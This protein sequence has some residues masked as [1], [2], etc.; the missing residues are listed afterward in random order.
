MNPSY[1]PQFVS[2]LRKL[3]LI[4]LVFLLIFGSVPAVFAQ[5]AETLANSNTEAPAPIEVPAGPEKV[6][7]TLPTGEVEQPQPV[8]KAP[9]DETTKDK[10]E[11]PGKDE[12]PETQ[13]LSAGIVT[14][15]NQMGKIVESKNRLSPQV[16][17]ITG[18]LVYEYQIIVPPG[19]NQMTPDVTLVYN[20]AT[21]NTDSIIGSGWDFSIP[22]IQRINKDGTNLMYSENYFSSSMD[23]ELLSLGSGSFGAKDENG[24]FNKYALAS[25]VWTVTDKTGTVYK[26][27]NTVVTRQ[28]N[29]A[30]T[31]KVFKWLLEEVRDIND[32]YIKYE[33]FKDAGQIYPSRIIY[34][35][36]GSTDG[37]FEVNFVRTTRTGASTLYN[38]GFSVKSNYRITEINTEVNNVWARKYTL[39]YTTGDNTSG[40]FLDTITESGQ[41]DSS[42]VTTLPISNFNYETAATDWTYSSAWSIPLPLG[43]GTTD[44][45][46]RMADIN[47]D[48]LVDL[49]CH[50]NSTNPDTFCPKT[51]PKVFLNDGDG[52]WT[53]VSS[54]WLFPTF[55][56]QPTIR[57]AFLE[58]NFT[59]TGL[60]ILD[61]NGD[62]LADLAR[63][64]GS[65]SVVYLNNGSG[66]THNSS[67]TVPVPFSPEYGNRVVDIN[68]DGLPDILCHNGSNNYDTFCPKAEPKVY[69]NNGNGTWT[70]VST[71][72]LFPYQ[73]NSTTL[74]E[75]FVDSSFRP[76][77]LTLIDI[78]GDGLADLTRKSGSASFVYLNNG[79]GWTWN[80]SWTLPL[81][82]TSEGTAP[83][84]G[85]RIADINGDSLS[86]LLCS[87][88]S[89]NGDTLCPNG[90]PLVYLNN[91]NGTWTDASSSWAFPQVQNQP[92]LKEV[93]L[94][95]TLNDTGLRLVDL[96]G[97]NMADLTRTSGSF[98][99]VYLNNEDTLSNLL[100]NIAHPQGGTTTMT[101]KATPLFKDG[102]N[103]LLNPFLPVVS[104]VVS[105][106]SNSDGL[107]LNET[108]NYSY[109]GGNYYFS[110]NLDRKLAGFN[111]VTRTDAAGNKTI[112]FYHQGNTTDSTNGEY[113]DHI[114]KLGRPYRVEVQNSTGSIFSKT[115]NQWDKYDLGSGR[116][117]VKNIRT[118]ELTYDGDS[119]H[120]DKAAEYTYEN[121]YGNLTTSTEWGE[122]TGSNDGTFTDT[123]T[124]KFT[125]TISYAA[126]TTPYIMGLPSQDTRVDQSSNKVSENNYY[127]D[128]QTQGNVTDG[129]LT[130]QEMW[131]T[132]STYIDIEKTY[133]TTY[134]I[135][136]QEKDPRDK[137]TNYSYDSYNLYPAT[138]TNA[139]SQVTSYTYDY[140]SGQVQQVTNLNTRVY[141]SVYD[142]LNRVTEQKQP[143][144]ATPS[145]LVTKTSYTYTDTSGAVKVQQ[146]DYLDGPTSVDTHTYFDGL[147]RP[148]QVR[149][150][151]EDTNT[152]AVVDTIYNDI[153]QVYKESVPYSS[154]GSAK[155][156]ATGTASLLITYSYDPMRRVSSIANAI[157]ATST[158]YDDW[159]T[160]ITDPR[161]KL[162][163][164]YNDAYGN[165]V[166][167][168]ETNFGNTYTTNY[169]YNGN[170][171]LT[172]I[173]DALGNVRNFTYDALGRRLTAQDSHAPTDG[174]YGSYTYTY[175]DSGNLTSVLDPKSQTINYV[176]DDLNRVATEDYAG[177]AGTEEIYTYDSGTDGKG[178]LTSVTAPAVSTTYAY[179]ANGN[180][181]QEVETI[182][183]TGYQ[184]DYTFDR[185]GNQLEITNP[186][187]SKIKYTYN[188]AGQLETVQRKE[189]TDGSFINVV[190]D[191]DYGPHGKMTY[192]ALQNGSA[193][194]NTYD[195][196]KMYRLSNKTTT[197]TGGSKMQDSTYTYDTNS[198]VTRIVDAS[199][200]N[201]AKTVDYTYD[202]LNRLLSAAATNVASGQSTYTHSY[203]YD[204]IGNIL[205]RTDAAGTYTYAGNQG[206]SYANPH[207]VT[208]IGS[209]NY[210]YDNNGNMLTETNGLSNVWDYDNRLAQTTAPGGAGS[211]TTVT[212]VPAAGD[213]SIFKD[214]SSNWD[215]AHDATSGV[216]ATAVATTLNVNSGK[217][218]T[219][220]KIER[221]FLPFDTSSIPDNATIT[222]VKLKVF[223]DSKLNSDNDGDDWVSVVQGSQPSTS[224]LTTADFDLAG[225]INS[226]TEGIDSS[227]RK[228][229][230]NVTT[231]Q[232]LVF[233]MNATGQGWV[234]KTAS[235]KLALR[236]G[237]DV[238]DSAYAGSS[239]TYNQ[240]TLRAGEYSDTSSDPILEVTYTTPPSP[241]V[242]TYAYN[243]DGQRVKLANGSTTTYYP[244][245]NYNTDG[246]TPMK[247]IF[248]GGI[249]VATVKG[250]GASATTYYDHTDHLT[251]SSVMTNSA[252][253]Q[254]ELMDYFPYGNIRLDQK[255]G[256]FSEQRKYTGH[257]YDTDTGL[258]YM[259]ARYYNPTI[260]RFLS[261]DPAFWE[262]SGT[263]LA[264]MLVDPQ[265]WNSYAYARNNPLAYVDPDGNMWTPWQS[266]GSFGNWMGNGGFLHNIY[267]S[268]VNSIN[269]T[270]SSIQQNGWT[271]DNVMA[272]GADVASITA[273]T[274]GVIVGS[275]GIGMGAGGVANVLSPAAVTTGTTAC[276]SGGC[277]KAQRA[278]T[279]IYND[280]VSRTL[281]RYPNANLPS[282]ADVIKN[283]DQWENTT[284]TTKT[285]SMLY[286]A[287]KH[288]DLNTLTNTGHNVWNS[289]VSNQSGLVNNVSQLRLGN[290]DMG[291]RI[292]L[293]D[294]SGGIFTNSGK[295]ISS[296]KK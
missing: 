100:T 86:D 165:L 47:G 89:N 125:T 243:Q 225:T 181:R 213:G 270:I 40:S 151:M 245:S 65:Y 239:S 267:G 68:G 292:R 147:G 122:V 124:D 279:T 123:G 98:S 85:V 237:H 132:G 190:T 105:Q 222:D 106:V 288:G 226:P 269:N 32:N 293:M 193:T 49:L 70:N 35:G 126:N 177:Q 136:T 160:S 57:E 99:I 229:I 64:S 266:S 276:A 96:N 200:T 79:S 21:A 72:W 87:N 175:D 51:V 208:S 11:K 67:W 107:G 150:E 56:N 188:T 42:T 199:N 146:S 272:L 263:H 140:S 230:T 38:P 14:P 92:T 60:R 271:K 16:D 155:T 143:D 241:V 206:A 273:K 244:S 189:S 30:D 254:E 46:T 20:S 13:S 281:S 8:S 289:Y 109:E 219:K 248:A 137:A 83:D 34:T 201:S 224:T 3:T 115:V 127:Y 153:G 48:G 158:A 261:Q 116:N 119:D 283:F 95:T 203:T 192:Q 238:I 112:T 28:D 169:E 142:G 74:R 12:D 212:F 149:K 41:D 156:S 242:V 17:N 90:N 78:N 275:V 157:G 97:D 50:N 180:R 234:S 6:V 52:T 58:S 24:S 216:T 73:G 221:A 176:Y 211:P 161:G 102:S 187:S 84:I 120:K 231:G 162:K 184:T 69:L 280:A 130:K 108:T 54:T 94:G 154:T 23:G 259:E 71:T 255:A 253:T 278:A 285:D 31:S 218:G 172:K 101:Y 133:N 75:E 163:H 291:L 260:G 110:T 36:N 128:E 217:A 274:S 113:L 29:S 148:I 204:A 18:A 88:R 265:S 39:A 77:G 27:G 61:L 236:E 287:A 256:S 135:V 185:Q 214:N 152:F 91:G 19:R 7:E 240:L 178:Q 168:D 138:V 167:V 296:W 15:I 290:G 257:E 159:K 250:T 295:I 186:D 10:K 129:N 235:T 117:F 197:I 196:A 82:P 43:E 44:Y 81:P 118:T 164:L 210:T 45:G 182:N 252:G 198:N 144:L 258:N 104:H 228:D 205:T 174:T 277:D 268:N 2:S 76:T 247:H 202:D 294:G 183:S 103:N 33:Y 262:F 195:S 53:D 284:F 246:T 26:F 209:I 4:V 62:N 93:F 233:N 121:T 139:L 37:I 5:E 207:A 191:F 223:V 22:Y 220:F 63:T 215:T 264:I 173:T 114:S 171:N 9:D 59:D 131:K 66:W 170:N 25:N 141:Q 227:E 55:P 232:Y 251:G 179:D 286:H 282:R 111:K 249:M 194:T 166:K 1:V 80:T 145:T 134:G